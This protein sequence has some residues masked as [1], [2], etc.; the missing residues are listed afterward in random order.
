MQYMNWIRRWETWLAIGG[1]V[2]A[3]LSMPGFGAAPLVFVALIPLFLALGKGRGLFHGYLFGLAFFAVDVRWILTLIRFNAL[4]A[5]GYVLLVAY[6]ALPFGLLGWL[7][8]R[9]ANGINVWR[10]I[11]LAPALFVLAEY[12][13][14]LGPL[15]TGFSMFH[16]AL[17]R[18]P[19]LIQSAS[20]LGS[21]SVTGFVVAVNAAWYV[22]FRRK[23]VRLAL[24]GLV[25]FLAQGAF[26]FLPAGSGDDG[27]SVTV[28]VVSSNVDQEVKLD[29]RNLSA[30]TERFIDLGEEA[31]GGAPDLVVFPE[32][33]LPAYILNVDDIFSRLADLARAGNTRLLF[34]TGTFR[35]GEIYNSTVLVDA[36]G[37]VIGIY[38]MVR[39]VPFG[40]YIP[41]R[42]VLEAI[43][44][45]EWTRALLPLDLTRG[46]GYGPLDGIG[47]PICFEST[48]PT[49]A[50]RLTQRGASLLVTVTNDAW[51]AGSSEL[52]AH[53]ASAVFR[54]VEN[55]R[56]VVQAAN[57]GISG[58]VDPRGRILSETSEEK[59]ST[60]D[61]RLVTA[62]SIYTRWGDAPFLLVMG[63][64]AGALIFLRFP[65]W[66]GRTEE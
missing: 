43:G 58:F 42:G 35:N 19:W 8:T 64:M 66:K 17:Y 41:G 7:M 6:L 12:V 40:E 15:G 30:F 46:T 22:A 61:V 33:F 24:L 34:G 28:A 1:G 65:R 2:M 38:D 31:I 23:S 57:G 37:D 4:V 9:R 50:R 55:R 16:Q 32:S 52:Q 48:F 47:T 45:G 13:R 27:S 21:W 36:K 18:V 3:A 54:A 5:P 63:C 39:P 62:R 44:L 14:T 10:W 60:G 29:G 49:A 51:F 11:L 56:A 25:L 26:W 20:I 59:V 53:F